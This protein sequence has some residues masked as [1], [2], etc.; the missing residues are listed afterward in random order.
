MRSVIRRGA[1]LA[2]GGAMALAATPATAGAQEAPAGLQRYVDQVSVPRIVKHLQAFQRIADTNGGT[3]ASGTRGQL[4][5]A[6][7]VVGQLRA[8]G[9]KPTVQA[10][11]F[12]FFQKL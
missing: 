3:R 8:A 12:F 6:R 4:Q 2:C 10:F 9:Y 1:V 7:Y 5:S 11:N